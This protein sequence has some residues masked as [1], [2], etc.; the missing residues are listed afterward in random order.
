[1]V[2]ILYNPY[3]KAAHIIICTYII[4]AE[5]GNNVILLLIMNLDDTTMIVTLEF[6]IDNRTLYTYLHFVVE[7]LAADGRK[8]RTLTLSPPALSR[9]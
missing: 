7:H 9:S 6:G 8:L 3:I 2:V 4:G 1:M 5:R